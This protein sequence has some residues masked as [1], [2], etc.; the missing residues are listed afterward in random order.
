MK[1]TR[2]ENQAVIDLTN[3]YS[4]EVAMA[5][6][7]TIAD[8]I[9]KWALLQPD[10]TFVIYNEQVISYHQVNERANDFARI[11]INQGLNRGDTVALMMEN[12]PEFF[13][14]WFGMLKL[15]VKTAFINT[16]AKAKALT[17]AINCVDSKLVLLGEECRD[18]YLTGD[19]LWQK[20]PTIEIPDCDAVDHQTSSKIQLQ[21]FDEAL[22]QAAEARYDKSVRAGLKN[23]EIACYIFTSGTTGL[24][25]A[26]LISHSKWLATG[27]RW[28]PMANITADDI[29][30][31]TLPLF[32]G[33]GV[34]SLY[35]SVIAMG[36]TSVLRRKFSTSQFWKDIA[37][38]R[39]SCFIYV[40]EI[41]RY[42]ANAEPVAEEKNHTVR[43]MLGSGMGADVWQKFTDRFG[44][45]IEIRE[46]WGSTEANCNMCN[47]ENV[48]GSCGRIPYWDRTFM[49][50]ISYN[51]ENS[52]HLRNDEG[53]C[54][55]AAPGA[56]GELIG[57]VHDGKG[58]GVSP[59]DGYT[60]VEAS[61]TK[62]L[63]NVFEDG[64]CWFSTGDLFNYDE[65][66]YFFFVD[67][68]GD[69]FRWKSENVSTT[70]VASQL[71]EY[72][73]A[74]LINIYGVKVPDTEGRAG[75]AALVMAATKAFNPQLFY[76]I[77]VNNLPAYA[78][79]LFVRIVDTMDMTGTFKLRKINL[80]AEG[81][82]PSLSH[83]QIFLL[84]HANKT[85]SPF[86]D[87]TLSVLG[88]QPFTAE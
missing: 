63:R 33:A 34:M 39:V 19:Q 32:H 74:E 21:Q 57:Q 45:H 11:G 24:P 14:A 71:I 86:S 85:Y 64:D 44:D 23:S 27:Q 2:D 47:V 72:E 13:Y 42:L 62:L 15:G 84:D 59:F 52:E 67:R 26:A 43:L 58:N 4:M 56:L 73:D 49:R 46:G 68:I 77:A 20:I 22:I 66:G 10:K 29:Y 25:K 30:Y 1:L 76:T 37:T 80:Q 70:E 65:E 5:A 75:M 69:T 48:P 87:E 28:I 40:G 50:M 60:D 35:S 7:V 81:Y 54:I 16:H 88:V 61:E 9:E 83:D 79:P 3:Q 82:D 17:H 78:V 38:H 55:Q 51:V 12:R 18:R 36:A 8:H 31:C 53:F 6:D 41:C